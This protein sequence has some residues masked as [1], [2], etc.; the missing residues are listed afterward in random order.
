MAAL[1]A[2][3]LAF[4][5][6][7][8]GAQEA[9]LVLTVTTSEAD[10]PI[11]GAE[12]KVDGR[13]LGITNADG[14]LRAAASPGAHRVEVRAIG[15]KTMGL[16][17][18]L[19]AGETQVDVQL[20]A[21]AVPLAPV[22]ATATVRSP[23]LSLF[24]DRAANHSNGVFYTREYIEH[25]KPTQLTDL[26]L[27]HSGLHY[28]YTRGG[29]R[30]IRFANAGCPPK[31]YINGN[32][33]VVEQPGAADPSLDLL[34]HIDE[35]EGVE[36]YPR[37]P[38]IEYGGINSGCGTILIW[39]RESAGPGTRRSSQPTAPP[40]AAPSPPPS[41][42]P[43]PAPL[44]IAAGPGHALPFARSISRTRSSSPSDSSQPPGSWSSTDFDA[45]L[46]VQTTR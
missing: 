12:L 39:L 34:V 18:V 37:L 2:A 22:N 14:V 7:R 45:P 15:R 4:V 25:R 41:G 35:V 19:A 33:V 36:V 9:V 44:V 23:M 38:P 26:L 31:Y 42:S 11:R 3:L 46:G 13:T 8:V 24:Y 43:P 17:G 29:H 20:D 6:A 40:S 16:Q 5:P 27:D 30:V 1:A 21:D 28:V 32:P 10:T